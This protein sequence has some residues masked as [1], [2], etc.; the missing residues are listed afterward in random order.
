VRANLQFTALLA[1]L[2]GACGG[3]TSDPLQ[4]S[5][6]IGDYMLVELDDQSMPAAYRETALRCVTTTSGSAMGGCGCP[7]GVIPFD[8]VRSGVLRIMRG[9]SFVIEWVVRPTQPGAGQT[10]KCT[11]SSGRWKEEIPPALRLSSQFCF[12]D[13][14]H[15]PLELLSPS[16]ATWGKGTML[17]ISGMNAGLPGRFVKM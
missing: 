2:A 1:A 16:N 15:G 17:E 5:A 9:G 12:I 14:C 7:P 8:T 13:G 6:A 10:G 4:I 11:V 3:S